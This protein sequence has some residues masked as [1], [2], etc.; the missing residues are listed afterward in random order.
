MRSFS[1]VIHGES[2]VG[3][4][5][6][7]DSAPAPRLILDA[8]GGSRF[9]PSQP[10]MVWDPTADPP[11]TGEGVETVIT[12]VRDF[13]TMT[14]VFQWLNSGAHAFRSVVLDSLTE[15]Q[16]RCLDAIA[17]VNQPTQQDWGALLRQM[18]ALVRQ[19][20]DLTL[21]PVRPIEVIAFLA[22]TSLDEVQER[23]PNL[24]GRLRLT[25]PAFV[26]AVGYL[27]TQPGDTGEL[28]RILLT[29]PY[30]GFV[31]KDRTDKLS[32]SI[33]NPNIM[34]MLDSIYGKEPEADGNG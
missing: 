13:D 28:N 4:S 32:G 21:H 26:D 16:K 27:Y 18:E 33:V 1:I 34:T 23:R 8:E 9:T 7:G 3:K 22:T 6:L 30:P 31:A 20:R 11:P 17:G 2:G 12:Y 5:W 29:Q 10:K 24:Q 19:Y 14:R 15:I 25:L